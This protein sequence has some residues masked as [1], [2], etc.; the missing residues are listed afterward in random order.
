MQQWH[1]QSY[2]W[3]MLIDT[4]IHLTRWQEHKPVSNQWSEI[5]FP[6][7]DKRYSERI[8]SVLRKFGM[9]DTE[10]FLHYPLTVYRKDPLYAT[11]LVI[12]WDRSIWTLGFPIPT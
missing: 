8:V 5:D 2:I 6:L 9:S 10:S 12:S 1:L 4:E 7:S 11:S 3:K